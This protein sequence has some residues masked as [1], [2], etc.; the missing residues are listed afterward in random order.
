MESQ[1]NYASQ[2]KILKFEELKINKFLGGFRK[3]FN[4]IF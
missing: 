3:F 2:L 1:A 4:N